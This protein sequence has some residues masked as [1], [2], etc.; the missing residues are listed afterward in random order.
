M[1]MYISVL[2][3]IL[4]ETL[5]I[6]ELA[7]LLATE[8]IATI[9]RINRGS[10]LYYTKNIGHIQKCSLQIFFNCGCNSSQWE[11]TDGRY[12]LLI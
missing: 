3:A 12:V 5:S 1:K 2:Q 10:K 8:Q 7:S 11:I 6:G 4:A 9:S